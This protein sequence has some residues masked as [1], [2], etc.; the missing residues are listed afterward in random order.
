QSYVLKVRQTSSDTKLAMVWSKEM[1]PP[2]S[3]DCN[4]LDYYVWGVL[5]RESNKRAHNSVV[6]NMNREHLV[7][8]CRRF[9]SRL[10]VVIEADGERLE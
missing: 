6:A 8:A 1:W 10:E 5:E 7:N 2:S 9:R 4:P 3:P